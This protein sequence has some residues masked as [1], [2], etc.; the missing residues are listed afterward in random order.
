MVV[1]PKTT[2]KNEGFKALYKYMGYTNYSDLTRPG[3]PKASVLA[4]K[5]HYFREI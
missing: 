1:D 5:S 2:W 3:P 4:G